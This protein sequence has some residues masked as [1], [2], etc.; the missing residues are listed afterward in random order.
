MENVVMDDSAL[1]HLLA[2]ER[3]L[4]RAEL[5]LKLGIAAVILNIA[6]TLGRIVF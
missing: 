4:R 6:I 1:K 5:F 3:F 2:A